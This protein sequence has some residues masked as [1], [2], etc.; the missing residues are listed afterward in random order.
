MSDRLPGM[1]GPTAQAIA[2]QAAISEAF[3][4]IHEALC[5]ALEILG[6]G[7]ITVSRTVAGDRVTVTLKPGVDK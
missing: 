2:Q 7:S 6:R 1:G 4:R 3:H 5:P